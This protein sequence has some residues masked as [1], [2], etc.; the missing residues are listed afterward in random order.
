MRKRHVRLPG[1]LGQMRNMVLRIMY[2]ML[3]YVSECRITC[4]TSGQ[5]PWSA[6]NHQDTHPVEGRA[7]SK[8]PI[9]D[10]F[11]RLTQQTFH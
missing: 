7:S 9:A 2:I 4:L 5:K 1:T 10:E 8:A 6:S 11:K 3:N